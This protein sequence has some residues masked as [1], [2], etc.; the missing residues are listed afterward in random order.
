M[1]AKK[2]TEN[3]EVADELLLCPW[4]KEGDFDLIGLKSHITHGDCK[5]YNETSDLIRIF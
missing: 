4:C 2:D 3:Q 5:I 1:D